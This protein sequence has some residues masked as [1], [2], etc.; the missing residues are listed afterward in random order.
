MIQ[1]AILDLLIP[2]NPFNTKNADFPHFFQYHLIHLIHLI[3]EQLVNFGTIIL[4][5]ILR[6]QRLKIY[7]GIY[8]VLASFLNLETRCSSSAALLVQRDLLLIALAKVQEDHVALFVGVPLPIHPR[9]KGMHAGIGDVSRFSRQFS[10][11]PT[12]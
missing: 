3:T 5:L 10:R 7:V 12:L 8:D 6:I 11:H 4:S 9:H 2:F 1:V